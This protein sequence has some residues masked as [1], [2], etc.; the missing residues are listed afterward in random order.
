[1]TWTGMSTR[2]RLQKRLQPPMGIMGALLQ[3]QGLEVRNATL[4]FLAALLVTVQA[5]AVVQSSLL[6]MSEVSCLKVL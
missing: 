1:M 3:V 4:E 6:V 2:S 5:Q